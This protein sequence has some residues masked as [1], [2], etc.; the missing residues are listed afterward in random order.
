MKICVPVSSPIFMGLTRPLLYFIFV[1][2]KK[3]YKMA[4]IMKNR[5][6]TVLSQNAVNQINDSLQN[7]LQQ[8]PEKGNVTLTDDDRYTLASLDVDNKAFVEDAIA[9]TLARGAGIIP[10]FIT[11]EM[12]QVDL[13]LFSQLDRVHGTLLD[14]LQRVEDMRR[15]AA[16]EAYGA[17]GTVYGIFD[18]AAQAGLPGAQAAY[19]KLKA[20]YKRNG[21]GSTPKANP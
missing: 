14:V 6:N 17:A 9:E 11:G 12:M 2:N 4:N 20:R 1:A 13:T 21:G 7:V 16:S 15:I 10:A 18:T 8:L 5:L 19:D 3:I